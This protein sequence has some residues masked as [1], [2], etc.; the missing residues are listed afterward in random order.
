M[1][2]A[3]AHCTSL[4]SLGNKIAV[5]RPSLDVVSPKSSRYGWLPKHFYDSKSTSAS[6]L[7]SISDAD[8]VL[9]CPNVEKEGPLEA[10]PEG[11][12][13]D[14]RRQLSTTRILFA[15]IGYSLPCVRLRRSY[16]QSYRAA[17]T[18]FLA[19]TDSVCA[20]LTF[21]FARAHPPLQTIVSTS[22]PTIAARFSASQTEYTWVGVSY[23]LTQTVCQP[24]YGRLSDLVGRKVS[25]ITIVLDCKFDM[26]VQN[27]LFS[28][29]LVFALGSLLC[30]SAQVRCHSIHF[31]F[32]TFNDVR[33]S[34]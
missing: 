5:P 6:T 21:C 24:F 12:C 32:R 2:S 30:G 19:T 23:M 18:L 15:H 22:L 20:S 10:V 4:F 13:A 16:S 27:L 14:G 33:S 3:I 17:L 28:S 7:P 26:I 25:L 11:L 34:P 31:A 29:I 8:S 9:P 1:F